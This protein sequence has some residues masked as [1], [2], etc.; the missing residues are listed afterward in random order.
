M[1]ARVIGLGGAPLHHASARWT[2]WEWRQWVQL[3]LARVSMVMVK[4]IVRLQGRRPRGGK[5]NVAGW[6]RRGDVGAI[7]LE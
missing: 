3:G 6:T 5:M 7:V 1:M 2:T 4:Q